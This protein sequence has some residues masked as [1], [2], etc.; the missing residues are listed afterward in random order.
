[1]DRAS[2]IAVWLGTALVSVLTAHSQG[3]AL[4]RAGGVPDAL[5]PWLIGAG[6]AADLL[7]GLWMW[8]A[9]GR[10]VYGV[11]L[12]VMTTMTVVATAID[13]SLWL[14]PLGPLLKNLPIA[15]MLWAL[16]HPEQ[17]TTR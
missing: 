12:A 5:H 14:H 11:A 7:L 4:L 6:T 10:M 8:L 16:M 9:P 3:P 2:L 15:A 13:P 17:G 1:M